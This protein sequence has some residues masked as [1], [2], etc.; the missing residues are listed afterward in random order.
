[1]MGFTNVHLFLYVTW[2]RMPVSDEKSHILTVCPYIRQKLYMYL[3]KLSQYQTKILI[4]RQ[5]V[6]ASDE[7][8]HN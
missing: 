6:P 4:S 2:S 3:H 1:M 8:P 7:K 5:T